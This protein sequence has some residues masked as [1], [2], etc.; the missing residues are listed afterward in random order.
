MIPHAQAIEI[1]LRLLRD[2]IDGADVL[3]RYIDQQSERDQ[4]ANLTDREMSYR[5]WKRSDEACARLAAIER[6]L[7]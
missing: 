6:L 3:A 1:V 4:F 2:E 5:A 7:R